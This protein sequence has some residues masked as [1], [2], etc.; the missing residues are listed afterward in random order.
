MAKAVGYNRLEESPRSGRH[1]LAHGE[2]RG[3]QS[4]DPS[5]RE[6]AKRATSG[7][8]QTKTYPGI[9][10]HAILVEERYHLLK[11]ADLPV[12]LLLILYVALHLLNMGFADAEGGVAG[13][14]SKMPTLRPTLF[15]PPGGIRFHLFHDV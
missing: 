3:T 9:I 4:T 6:P 11:E 12:V 1:R 8:R 2:S 13:L 14:P 7:F 5:R 10:L 15:H